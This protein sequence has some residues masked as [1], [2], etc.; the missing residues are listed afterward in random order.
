MQITAALNKKKKKKNQSDVCLCLVGR[1]Q[2]SHLSTCSLVALHSF[3]HWQKKKVLVTLKVNVYRL[4]V[5][6]SDFLDKNNACRAETT[7]KKETQKVRTHF[8]FFCVNFP[9]LTS[10]GGIL[11]GVRRG[12]ECLDVVKRCSVV[13][14]FF[15]V[16][17]I[18]ESAFNWL[19]VKKLLC[20]STVNIVLDSL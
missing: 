19:I 15:Y 1:R 8:F 17:K 7:M 11:W 20:F 12:E 13:D 4:T 18:W 3:T 2:T 6:T 10:C 9:I 16:L 5:K 14:S